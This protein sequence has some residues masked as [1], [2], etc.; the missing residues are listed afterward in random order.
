M[1]KEILETLQQ[2]RLYTLIAAK[3]MLTHEEA[4]AYLGISVHH[5]T[6]L[7]TNRMIP[8]Y[9]P[10]GKLCYYSKSDLDEFMLRGKVKSFAQMDD[11][12]IKHI[13]DRYKLVP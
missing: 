1:D 2:I 10:N 4:S 3:Q 8:Y 13:A 5:L 12:A 9:K 6:K 7:K 11:D